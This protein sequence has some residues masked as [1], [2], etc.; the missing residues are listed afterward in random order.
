MDMDM[1]PLRPQTYLFTVGE[2]AESEVEEEEVV[3]FLSNLESVLTLEKA[4]LGA[5]ENDD[6]DDKDDEGEEEEKE[7]EGGGGRGRGGGGGGTGDDEHDNEEE[8]EEKAPVKK[9]Q[10][11]NVPNP[12]KNRKKTLK[13]PKGPSSVED[14]KAKM[15]VSREKGGFLT[16]VEA[17]FINYVK[18]CFQMTD[19]EVIQ[20]L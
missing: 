7:E 8:A 18:N 20:D 16:R 13:T 10:D 9:N 6:E 11:Q 15:Q 19:Q 1:S 4:K 17:R 14:I 3:K 2:D 5:G 12:S